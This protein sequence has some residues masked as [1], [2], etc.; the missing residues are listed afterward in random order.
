[1][2]VVGRVGEEDPQTN[3]AEEVRT[4]ESIAGLELQNSEAGSSSNFVWRRWSL[5]QQNPLNG[6]SANIM[7]LVAEHLRSGIAKF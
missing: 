2:V 5:I 3:L 6:Y 7:A 4:A 1:M